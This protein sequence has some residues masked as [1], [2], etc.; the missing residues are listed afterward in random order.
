MA[1]KR[2]THKSGKTNNYIIPN[3]A[4]LLSILLIPSILDTLYNDSYD[5]TTVAGKPMPVELTDNVID[6]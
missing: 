5:L 4:K 6:R 3:T 1:R 2:E